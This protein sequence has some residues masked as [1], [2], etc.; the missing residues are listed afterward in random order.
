[1]NRVIVETNKNVLYQ[2]TVETEVE[3]KTYIGISANQVKKRIATHKTTINSKPDDRNYLQYKQA[4]E[5]SKL[6]HKLK[7]ENKNYKLTW[8]ILKKENKSKPGAETCR[9]YLNKTC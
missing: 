6:T 3:S 2:A 4:T 8:K 1:M 7:S 5:L 9:L